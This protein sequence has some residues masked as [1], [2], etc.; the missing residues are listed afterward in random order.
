MHF[1]ELLRDDMLSV[2]S[3][4][5]AFIPFMNWFHDSVFMITIGRT[6]RKKKQRTQWVLWILF[7]STTW[8]KRT[9]PADAMSTRIQ[10]Y[11][12]SNLLVPSSFASHFLS[13]L[14][15]SLLVENSV[16]HFVFLYIKILCRN[17]DGIGKFREYC[18]ESQHQKKWEEN[19]IAFVNRYMAMN[20]VS[21]YKN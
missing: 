18:R 10:S 3:F 13:F 5:Q 9:Q 16:L 7:L 6:C 4:S 15:N 12:N 21:R 20:Q 14:W 17:I 1:L 11:R 2:W 8:E 19:G